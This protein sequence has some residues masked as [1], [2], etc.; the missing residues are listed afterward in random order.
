MTA[1]SI[2]ATLLDLGMI[3]P[4]PSPDLTNPEVIKYL[5]T[6]NYWRFYLSVPLI[7]L[8]LSLGL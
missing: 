6:S 8:I 2:L 1:G 4:F 7:A 5:K 3:L